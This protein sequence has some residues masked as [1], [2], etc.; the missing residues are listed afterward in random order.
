[1]VL[2]FSS[3]ALLAFDAGSVCTAFVR[4]GLRSARAVSASS[5]RLR[6]GALVPSAFERNL[7]D[8]EEVVRAIREALEPLRSH[9]RSVTLV[10]PH[11]VSRVMILDR[12]R[13]QD[14]TEYARFRLGVSLP[15]PPAEAVVD[16]LPLPGDR[17]LA[18]AVRR[19]VVAEYEEAAAAAGI[20]RG[21]VDLAP[22]AAA[23]GAHPISTSF[24]AATVFLVLGDVAS[25][26][27]A[28]DGG[29]L[30]GVRIRRRDLERGEAERLRQDAFRTA[31]E[32]GLRGEPELVVAGCGADGILDHWA[33]AGRGGRL[34]SLVPA[35]GPLREAGARPW[36]AAVLA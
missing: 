27:F 16:F 2:P 25:C 28:Y 10:L 3:R 23:A 36:L 12:P 9:T 1:V 11:G 19:E 33:A 34:L 4:R 24:A 20:T 21:R 13:A 6:E 31:V 29:L 7:C 5:S 26:F 18:A 14:P 35:G 15:Y 30:R 8:P 17:M 32:A 22:L